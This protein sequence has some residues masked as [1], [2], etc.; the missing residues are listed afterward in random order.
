MTSGLK[1]TGVRFGF[2]RV[3]F[4]LWSQLLV[5]A[6]VV[7]FGRIVVVRGLA[8]ACFLLSVCAGFA[9]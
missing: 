9:I 4:G 7:L 3:A 5:V 1:L 8:S 2:L 6:R